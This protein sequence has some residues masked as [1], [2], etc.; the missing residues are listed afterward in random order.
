MS[1]KGSCSICRGSMESLPDLAFKAL[2]SLKGYQFETFLVG[3]SVAQDL[4]DNEDEFRSKFKIKGRQS[5]KGQ[6][7]HYV[8]SF[9]SGKTRRSV[10]HSR[11][12]VTILLTIPSNAVYINPRSIWLS[13]RY[14]KR[15]RGIAQ[16]SSLC[17]VCN[18][19]GCSV[20]NYKGSTT[21]TLQ[22]MVTDF[23]SEL[24]QAE[25]CNFIWIGNEDDQSLVGGNGR[26][27][28]VEV[29]KPKRRPLATTGRFRG[30][31]PAG[32]PKRLAL[33]GIL[34]KAIRLLQTKPTHIPQLE[35]KCIVYLKWK[36]QE[37]TLSFEQL[38]S[39]GREISSEF[40][41]RPVRIKLSKRNKSINRRI[42][43]ISLEPGKEPDLACTL[44]IGAEGGVPI[45]KLVMGTDE[46][47]HPN[48]SKYLGAF[49][50]DQLRPF[51][52][53]DIETKNHLEKSHGVLSP[54]ENL[55]VASKIFEKN[56]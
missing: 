27:F 31:N 30:R 52:V 32:V 16:R 21:E 20:C 38:Q 11:P 9:I 55:A 53:I 8:G 25:G 10:E 17:K 15:K 46:E 5:I 2:S 1:K 3:S 35:M 47:V 14:R 7:S 6:V 28:F 34:L 12:D 42:R 23:L 49:A 43:Y 45:R 19:L 37:T 39:I 13:A 4:I 29:L 33:N 51:D 26:P 50:L 22:A 18:G 54:V 40:S 48:L 56:V 44:E 36:S 24:F 41:D